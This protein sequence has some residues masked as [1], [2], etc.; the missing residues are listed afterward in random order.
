MIEGILIHETKEHI[1]LNALQLSFVGGRDD[2]VIV[3]VCLFLLI[4]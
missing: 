3:Y 4:S 1:E 2:L